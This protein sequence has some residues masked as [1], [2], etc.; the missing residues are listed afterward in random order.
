MLVRRLKQRCG[1]RDLLHIGTSAT[2]ISNPAAPPQQRR[3]AVAA[4]AST[5]FGVAVPPEHSIEES[6]V[7]IS[8][9]PSPPTPEELR[10]ALNEPRPA[11]IE[12][13]F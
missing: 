2:M 8:R 3:Q 9:Q 1:N 6:L 12:Q 10:T 5:L 13:V 11:R 7:P 4:F